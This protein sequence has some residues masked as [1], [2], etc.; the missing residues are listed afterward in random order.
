MFQPTRMLLAGLAWL[1]VAGAVWAQAPAAALRPSYWSQRVFMIPYRDSGQAGAQRGGVELLVS[2]DGVSDWR[3][4]QQAQR[5]VSGFSFHAPEDGDYWFAV[6]TLNRR[7]TAPDGFVHPQLRVVVDTK[8]PVLNLRA[9]RGSGG[10]VVLRYEATDANLRAETLKLQQQTDGGPW[11]PV[12]LGKPDVEQQDRL[13]G[14][15]TLDAQRGWRS[16]A[17]RASI[18]DAAGN[19]VQSTTQLAA[20]SDPAQP[21]GVAD[22]GPFLPPIDWPSEAGR[23]APP[24]NNPYAAPDEGPAFSAGIAPPPQTRFASAGAGVDA[25]ELGRFGRA[26][27]E[28]TDASASPEP[29]GFGP[30][31]RDEGWNAAD[32]AETASSRA[33]NALTFDLD[34]ELDT[35]GP[36]GVSRVEIWASPDNGRSWN[37]LTIDPDNRSPARV[38][39]PGAGRYGFRLVVD[40]ANGSVARR[41]QPG[42]EPELGVE[43][44][45]KE[46]IARLIE[47]RLG[48]GNLTGHL[49]LKWSATDTNLEDRPVGLFYSSS[50]DGP[51]STIAT[52]LGNS[53]QYTWRLA[54]HVPDRFYV[55]LEVRDRAGNVAVTRS[56]L[57]V[58]VQRPR[59]QGR[60]RGARPAS[61]VPGV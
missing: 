2:R 25:P 37:R 9:T 43:V 59:P 16:L 15:S 48:E 45:L 27:A 40:G 44:D 22:R 31:V 34:Y 47:T 32:P 30:A 57:P 41:P 35:V 13:I 6:R 46:P 18:A 38:T 28:Q 58:A 60:L 1:T 50:P 54:R 51:W 19:S 3:V 49:L 8:K 23:Q 4:L 33:V 61:D 24:S 55:R 52:G 10:S 20:G 21:I 29:S 17:V 5:S 42:D 12:V 14:R 39:V 7:G 53:G 11:Q 56:E 26:L 36:W